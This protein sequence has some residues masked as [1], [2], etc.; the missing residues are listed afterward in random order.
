M[1]L[2]DITKG[3]VGSMDDIRLPY[4]S[5]KVAYSVAFSF[6]SFWINSSFVSICTG[7]KLLCCEGGMRC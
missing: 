7:S 3:L 4:D 5:S 2:I 1:K 6:A